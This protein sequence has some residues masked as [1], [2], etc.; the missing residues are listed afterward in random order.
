MILF[1]SESPPTASAILIQSVSPA[2]RIFSAPTLVSYQGMNG[3][4]AVG[5]V[6]PL[7]SD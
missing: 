1:L 5:A 2:L 3:F 6:V 7:F 4:V